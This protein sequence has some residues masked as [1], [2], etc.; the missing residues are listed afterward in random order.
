[1]RSFEMF[2]HQVFLGLII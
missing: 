2:R 1:M